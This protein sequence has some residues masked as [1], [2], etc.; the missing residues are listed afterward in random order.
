M[1][2]APKLARPNPRDPIQTVNLLGLRPTKSGA[3][4]PRSVAGFD[5]TSTRL[6]EV[7]LTLPA[8]P[9]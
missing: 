9:L 8:V 5:P 4:S 2:R 6:R 7:R 1:G 3:N